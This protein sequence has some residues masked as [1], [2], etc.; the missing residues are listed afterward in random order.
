MGVIEGTS[1]FDMIGPIMIGPSSSHAAGIVRIGRIV[2]KL[3]EAEPQRISV[4]FYNSFAS[5]YEGHKSDRAIVA[6]LLNFQTDDNRIKNAVEIARTKDIKLFFESIENAT[7][8]YHNTIRVKVEFGNRKVEAL[9]ISR[10]G[11]LITV[12]EIDGF[13]TNLSGHYATLV[14]TTE[15]VH[16]AIAH[17][18]R[19]MSD[20]S[21][22]IA[23]L[24]VTRK[25]G[26]NTVKHIYELDSELNVNNLEQLKKVHWIKDLVYIPGSSI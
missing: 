7:E 4:T 16:D 11:G 22:N 23:E 3:L 1:I 13:H 2:R 12:I 17:I 15:D 8:L 19:M 6:G 21:C 18:T 26:N 5:T 20:I 25:E 24:T 14:L 10:G 9:A